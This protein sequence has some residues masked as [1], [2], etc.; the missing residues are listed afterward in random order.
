MAEMRGTI[1]EIVALGNAPQNP[2]DARERGQ[3]GRGRGRIGRLAVVDEKHPVLRRHPLH[4][5]GQA[6]KAFQTRLDNLVGQAQIAHRAHGRRGIGAVVRAL[7]RGPLRLV[8]GQFHPVDER[9]CRAIGGKAQHVLVHLGLHV[10]QREVAHGL[11]P[12]QSRL[13]G[14]IALETVVAVEM[15]GRDVEQDGHVGVDPLG[16]VDLVARQFEHIDAAC[17]QR[18]LFEDRLADIAAHQRG[19]ARLREQV[20]G[21]RGGGRLAVGSG[22]RHHAVCRQA[23]ACLRKQFDVAD[24]R[25]PRRARMGGDGMA[26]ERHAGRDDDARIA[27]QINRQRIGQRHPPFEGHARFLA[28][29]PRGHLRAAGQQRFDRRHA[30]AGKAQHGITL[31]GKGGRDDH[32]T[33]SVARPSSASTIETIQKR[34]TTVDSFQPSCS[35]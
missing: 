33:F 2:V 6:D 28:R 23:C 11:H 34:I 16:Q 7:Q 20:I 29:V 26:V 17:G 9:E 18:L 24:H 5:V 19:N 32:R 12:E 15:V 3:R 1:I 10:D 30:R 14:D 25:H 31:S 35:K 21:Q 13:G 4:A 8:A 27:G 22:D